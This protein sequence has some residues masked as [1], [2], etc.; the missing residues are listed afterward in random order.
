MLS[1]EYQIFNE[2]FLQIESSNN[3][4]KST[5][6]S[7]FSLVKSFPGINL[8]GGYLYDGTNLF[9][10]DSVGTIHKTSDEFTT[11]STVTPGLAGQVALTGNKIYSQTPNIT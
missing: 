9:V 4:Y 1:Q 2:R 7:S 5:N 11:S 10:A 6:G 8:N 3:I